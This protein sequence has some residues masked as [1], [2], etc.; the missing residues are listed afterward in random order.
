[1]TDRERGQS[2]GI[3]N[4]QKFVRK[5]AWENL[6]TRT[7]EHGILRHKRRIGNWIVECQVAMSGLGTGIW[8]FSARK[9]DWGWNWNTGNSMWNCIPI[10][11]YKVDFPL[12]L[13]PQMETSRG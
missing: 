9:M 12:W 8:N 13:Q 5:T 1:M 10:P 11:E 7:V 3:G 2:C 4:A 6:W